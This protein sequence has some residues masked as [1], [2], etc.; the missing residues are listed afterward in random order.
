MN[1]KQMQLGRY[2]GPYIPGYY[3]V[4]FMVYFWSDSSPILKEVLPTDIGS[5]GKFVDWVYLSDFSYVVGKNMSCLT[6]IP[7]G[8]AVLQSCCGSPGISVWDSTANQ[9][10]CSECLAVKSNDPNYSGSPAASME[11]PPI[12]RCKNSTTGQHDWASYQGLKERF[13]YCRGCDEKR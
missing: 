6:V 11:A 8:R 9:W 4:S 3:S 1:T 10:I 2:Y 12:N 5:L 7:T 13:D